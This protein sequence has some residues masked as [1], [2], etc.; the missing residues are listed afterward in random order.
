[1]N[2][3]A[4][5]ERCEIKGGVTGALAAASLTVCFPTLSVASLIAL[6]VKGGFATDAVW[7]AEPIWATMVQRDYYP[8]RQNQSA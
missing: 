6:R 3:V 5:N 8:S 1:M 4:W 2:A 7:P